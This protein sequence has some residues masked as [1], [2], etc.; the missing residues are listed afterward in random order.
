[1]TRKC[2]AVG[3]AKQVPMK[4]LMCLPH[5]ALVPKWLKV[6]IYAAYMASPPIGYLALCKEAIAIVARLEGRVTL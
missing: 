5:W 1:M 2:C 6:D 4:M 3:C